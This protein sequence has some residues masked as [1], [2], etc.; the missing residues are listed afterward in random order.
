MM[1]DFL[2]L[3]Q[4]PTKKFRSGTNTNESGF[5]QKKKNYF[6]KFFL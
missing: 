5:T 4:P 3:Q 1:A 6:S 2:G